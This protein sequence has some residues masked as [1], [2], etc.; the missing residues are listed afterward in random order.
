MQRC[1]RNVKRV[2]AT[3]EISDDVCHIFLLCS[4]TGTLTMIA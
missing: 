2:G 4:S 1:S 3:W